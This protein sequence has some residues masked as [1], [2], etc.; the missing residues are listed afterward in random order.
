MLRSSLVSYMVAISKYELDFCLLWNSTLVILIVFSFSDLYFFLSVN[1]LILRRSPSQLSFNLFYVQY[2]MYNIYKHK[3]H[4][5]NA[6]LVFFIVFVFALLECRL[7]Q[8]G[9]RATS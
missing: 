8:D 4:K 1:T 3:Y 5:K 2:E 9:Y 7:A 6:C